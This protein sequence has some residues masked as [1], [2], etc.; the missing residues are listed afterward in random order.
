M[1]FKFWFSIRYTLN[2]LYIL[3]NDLARINSPNSQ[4]WLNV[5]RTQNKEKDKKKT[6]HLLL[7]VGDNGI[8]PRGHSL[9]TTFKT[10]LF[11]VLDRNSCLRGRLH[12]S[13]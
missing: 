1:K 11:R 8:P 5:T 12:S 10:M 2:E 13:M 3:V 9:K 6:T 4:F 7:R